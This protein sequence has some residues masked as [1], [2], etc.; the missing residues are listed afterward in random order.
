MICFDL[1]K[2]KT[3]Q[4]VRRW[5]TAVEQNCEEGIATM[6][7][8]TKCDLTEDRAV[9]REEAEQLAAEHNMTYFETSARG[10]IN[11]QE[12]F[13]EM[14]DAVYN[15]KFRDPNTI[16]SRDTIKLRPSAPAGGDGAATTK[17]KKGCC[18]GK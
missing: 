3:F 4:S 16:P 12:A 9:T 11:I 18:G 10:N 2:P 7:I 14:I 13:S 8:G 15:K 1:T 5:V 17:K 6:L